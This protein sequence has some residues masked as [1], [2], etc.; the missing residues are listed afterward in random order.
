MPN[1]PPRLKTARVAAGT[2][3]PPAKA[4]VSASGRGYDATWR[5]VRIAHLMANPVCV[6]PGCGRAAVDVDHIVPIRAGGG[7]LD[8]NNLQSFCHSCHS[9][10]TR[11][12][13]CGRNRGDR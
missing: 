1:R 2:Y 13:D 11:R 5:K 3:R 10:K 9:K 7:R 4:R 12:R 8:R 6:T